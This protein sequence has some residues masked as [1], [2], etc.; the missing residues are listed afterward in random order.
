MPPSFAFKSAVSIPPLR[1]EP[2]AAPRRAAPPTRQPSFA[3]ALKDCTNP[4]RPSADEPAAKPDVKAGE[5]AA[6]LE[7]PTKKPTQEP[8]TEPTQQPAEDQ[9]LLADKEAGQPG[10]GAIV[11]PVPAELP[12]IFAPAHVA[13]QTAAL[14]VTT[15]EAVATPDSEPV[16]ALPR[17]DI[18][19][20]HPS[21]PAPEAATDQPKQ[22]HE[23]TGKYPEMPEGKPQ[24]DLHARPAPSAPPDQAT[25]PPEASVAPLVVEPPP[26][27][28]V[29]PTT[30]HT[31]AARAAVRL[32]DVPVTIATLSTQG[33]RR[34]EIRLDPA[35]L[36][37]IEVTL[38]VD[39]DGGVRT[40]IAVE[41]AETLHLLR[42]DAPRLEQA[43]TAAGMTTD[44]NGTAFSLRSD[45]GQRQ[46]QG[47]DAQAQA[48]PRNADRPDQPTTPPA[49]PAYRPLHS[50]AAALDLM[51]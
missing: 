18:G 51:L 37:R 10:D 26:L 14:P 21:A 32:E 30:T 41:R 39:A 20:Q 29:T 45:S 17:T 5:S 3:E 48:Q 19:K 33:E 44:P 31:I 49:L 43:L 22:E 24:Q 35:S 12:V 23:T 16:V 9:K 2:S 36:G 28:S 11:L 46:G 6:N 47:H 4:Q 42:N 38:A 8:V 15:A 1:S 13:G 40:H 7:K 27:A 50:A 25:R 34:F